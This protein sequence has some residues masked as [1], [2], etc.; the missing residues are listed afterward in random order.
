MLSNKSIYAS[1]C[2]STWSNLL[3][4]LCSK[5]CQ[6]N[7]PTPSP[8]L[9]V[10]RMCSTVDQRRIWVFL[11]LVTVVV[12]T[13]SLCLLRDRSLTSRTSKRPAIA[14]GQTS[15]G[16]VMALHYSDQ[17][18]GGANNL[19]SMQCWA[20]TLGPRVRIVEPFLRKAVLGVDDQHRISHHDVGDAGAGVSIKFS[21]IFDEQHWRQ[22]TRKYPQLVSW[23]EFVENARH[24]KAIIVERA[25]RGKQKCME[26]GDKRS[27]DLLLSIQGLTD[28]CGFE[29]VR[30]VCY[31]RRDMTSSEFKKLIYGNYS[32]QEVVVVFNFWGG[33]GMDGSWQWHLPVLDLITQCS[34]SRTVHSFPSSRKIKHDAVEYIK[35]YLSN[36]YVS[37]M[38]R[39]EILYQKHHHF[40]GNSNDEI[41]FFMEQYYKKITERV[42]AFKAKHK[43]RD[44]F[45]AVDCRKQGT[46][47]SFKD[48]PGADKV[49]IIMASTIK[50]LYT[51]LYG[52]TST[53][54]DWDESFYNMSTF[55]T[56][57][58]IGMLQRDLAARGTC[59]ITA[60][61]GNFQASARGLHKMYR[62]KNNDCVISM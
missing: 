62:G 8:T 52:N 1:L 48:V 39:L 29:V 42:S 9:V 20:N 16:Y 13:V 23:N 55:E 44:V 35:R 27:D 26:C 7:P 33:I 2:S 4:I 47:T 57:G 61:G 31:P 12:G 53:L 37:V 34:R 14:M 18:T 43:I 11:V 50:N 3:I 60:G 46:M 38:V 36:K 58:Y 59:L 40:K 30:K 32:A 56:A 6:H 5:L 45:L 24:L 54:E 28:I 15:I 21:D 41:L 49:P 22:Q 25:C 51:M 19:V 10:T 17:M